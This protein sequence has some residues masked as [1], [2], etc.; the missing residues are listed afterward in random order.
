MKFSVQIYI[1]LAVLL[2]ISAC[3]D[4]KQSTQ[5]QKIDEDK[6]VKVLL[7]VHIAEGAMFNARPT[8]KDSMTHTYLDQI[9]KIHGIDS[10]QFKAY[11]DYIHSDLTRLKRIYDKVEELAKE[12]R[13]RKKEKMNE[14]NN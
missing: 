2:C 6:L 9:Y 11:L 10:I 14:S 7:D 13:G 8:E 4:Q 1:I 5:A 3:K 12:K